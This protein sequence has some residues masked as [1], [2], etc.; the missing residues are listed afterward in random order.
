M[1]SSKLQKILVRMPNWLGDAVMGT[2]ILQDLKTFLPDIQLHVLCHEA[3]GNLL[4]QNPYIDQSIIFANEKKRISSEKRKIYSRLQQENY[5]A[6]ILLTRSFSSA[7]WLWRGNIK[8]RI[9]FKDH[10]RSL[11]LTDSLDLPKEEETEHQVITYKRLLDPLSIPLSNTSPE[12]FLS[13]NERDQAQAL[14]QEHGITSQHTIIGINPGAAFGSAKC[15]P[16]ERF[17]ELTKRLETDPKNRIVYFG[18]KTTKPLCD[19]ITKACSP[20]VCNLAAK[21]TLRMLIALI[22]ET[23]CFVTN[24]SGPMHV[25]A[26]LGKKLIALF[27]S[28]NEIKT[29][30]YGSTGIVVHKH[31]ACSPCYKRHCPIDFRCMKSIEVDEIY[32]RITGT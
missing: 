8:R 25:A 1:E 14:L 28:T 20:R 10:Y 21:T 31:V 22:N 16:P 23:D 11:L 3:I 12:L 9:G 7:W 2:P 32:S 24:D 30:P 19:S 6:A 15:W 4:I 13:Q 18:D 29:G 27:G 17:L 26:A 5:D